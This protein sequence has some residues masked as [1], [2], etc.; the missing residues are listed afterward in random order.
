MVSR[1]S[2]STFHLSRPRHLSQTE[3]DLNWVLWSLLGQVCQM[4]LQKCR[5]CL[6]SLNLKKFYHSFQGFAF[7]V[8]LLKWVQE[9]PWR[10]SP[11][12][13]TVILEFPQD[14]VHPHLQPQI[15][16]TL[17]NWCVSQF[18]RRPYSPH[19]IK[20]LLSRKGGGYHFLRLQY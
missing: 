8:I 2:R 11:P 14:C 4:K 9:L 18:L 6:L 16:H 3:E 15:H 12:V 20:S 5:Q 17:F 7:P 1:T 13:I 10:W 19:T